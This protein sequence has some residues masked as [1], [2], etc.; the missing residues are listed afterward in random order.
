MELPEHSSSV[1]SNRG[2]DE[3]LA[4]SEPQITSPPEYVNPKLTLTSETTALGE[5]DV[6]HNKRDPPKLVS[7]D[8][9][10]LPS[11]Q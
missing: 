10:G 4:P 9:E 2:D 6:P 1:A 7:T 3:T 11:L 5:K 8:K